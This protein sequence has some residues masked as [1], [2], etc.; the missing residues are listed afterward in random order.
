[1]G[2]NHM[3]KFTIAS[4]QAAM[5]LTPL[6]AES[7]MLKRLQGIV[8]RPLEWAFPAP[9]PHTSMATSAP[10][11]AQPYDNRCGAMAEGVVDQVAH[12]AAEG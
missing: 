2:A 3:G 10:L 9:G 11:L 5:A 7:R 6:R 4:P 8:P 1:M 12:G